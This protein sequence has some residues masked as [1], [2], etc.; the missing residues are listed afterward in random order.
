VTEMIER[1]EDTCDI[2]CYSNY[3][4]V[5][6]RTYQF[7]LVE[8]GPPLN[9]DALAHIVATHTLYTFNGKRYDDNMLSLALCGADNKELKQAN[10]A[11]IKGGLQPWNFHDHFN[12]QPVP[13]LD[14]VDVMEVAPGVG[15]SLKAYA[16]RM[17]APD[18]VET[19]SDFERPLPMHLRDATVHYCGNDNLV[20]WQMREEL[21][22][23]L[24]LRRRL[25]EKYGVD[26][27]SKSDAQ[28]AEA[29]I[30]K[31]LGFKPEK[32][33]V[34]HGY[35]FNYTPPDYIEFVTPQMR[36]FLDLVRNAAFAVHDK[37]EALEYGIEGIR[38]GVK[39]PKEL[40]GRDIVMGESVYRVGIGG[41][42]SRESKVMHR[43][44]PG[45]WTITDHDVASY[46]P[47]LIKNL[48]MSPRQLGERFMEIYSDFIDQRLAAKRSGQKQIADSLKIV[49]N[50][51]FGKLLSKYSI[52]FAPEFGMA[53]TLTGQLSLL[54][55][56]E[57]LELVGIS[58]LSANTDGI[59]VRTPVGMER[60]R[61][62]IM[63]WWEAKTRL[64]LE[65][66]TYRLICS[67]DVNNY[68]AIKAN[69]DVKRNGIFKK[70]GLINNKT[71]DK[72][73]CAE[74]VVRYIVDGTPVSV[75]IRACKDIREFI[76]VR[77][78]KKGAYDSVTG[79]PIAKIV[80]WYYST[81]RKGNYLM[82]PGTDTEPTLW[83]LDDLVVQSGGA[84]PEGMNKV[85]G[86]DGAQPIMSLPNEMPADVDYQHYIT[87]AET[88]LDNMGYGLQI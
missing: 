2:E 30:K 14:T 25:S 66:A 22:E 64:E 4:L 23:R 84:A 15:L 49:L 37:E 6:G 41:L 47:T 73:I 60:V 82:T 17:H 50:G 53:T 59:V 68:V 28:V 74:A 48:G 27:R 72:S 3:F 44:I 75:T 76:V 46:Y 83:D 21:E 42:H 35:T 79:E 1:R 69:G 19:A 24:A 12:I 31:L 70:P 87:I 86:S 54:M 8:G 9:L 63:Q 5:K 80:R 29:L 61:D 33:I 20:T 88:M 13:Y 57:R 11:L 16:G 32:R 78:A 18:M 81:R 62:Y 55:L 71:P 56:I 36:E 43:T 40:K 58:V 52:M 39:I 77:K 10:D 26:V 45:K 65:A 67:R 38:T 7:E 34:K 51:T 85:A